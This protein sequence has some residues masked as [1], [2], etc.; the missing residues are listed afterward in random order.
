MGQSCAS[1]IQ[2][3][4][5]KLDDMSAQLSTN[6]QDNEKQN[7]SI[8]FFPQRDDTKTRL[9]ISC[10]AA[11]VIFLVMLPCTGQTHTHKEKQL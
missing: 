8:F 11:L 5:R 10:R 9:V 6:Y 3:R 4:K 2:L 1:T 7:I